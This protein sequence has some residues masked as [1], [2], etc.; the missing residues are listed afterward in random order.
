[1]EKRKIPGVI[2]SYWPGE[3][4]GGII[5]FNVIGLLLSLSLG[6]VHLLVTPWTAAC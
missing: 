1:V 4:G 6:P 3:A 5:A 2:G